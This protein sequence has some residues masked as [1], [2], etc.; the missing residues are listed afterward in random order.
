MNYCGELGV[1]TRSSSP[2]TVA[3]NVLPRRLA[4]ALVAHD[5]R[6]AGIEALVEHVAPGEF[7]ADQVPDQLVEFEPIERRH[8]GRAP[9]TLEAVLELGI[10]NEV[11]ARRH[12]QRRCA[13]ERA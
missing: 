2:S 7:R 1:C 10:G 13:R 9:P 6:I 5:D 8:R 4:V 12:L 11:D 3:W